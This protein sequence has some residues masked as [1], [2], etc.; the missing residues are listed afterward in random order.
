MTPKLILLALLIFHGEAFAASEQVSFPGARGEGYP[1]TE[2]VTGTLLI[3][4]N[5]KSP[6]P[7]IVLLHGSGGIDGRGAFHAQALNKAGIATLE[8]FMFAGGNRFKAG[9]TATLSH[10]YGALKFLTERPN[11]DSKKI[12]VMGFSWGGN[13]SLRTASK[14]VHRKFFPDGSPM[15][16][17]HA[18]YYAVW[19]VHT[20]LLKNSS[21]NGYG[22]YAEMT[23]A[24][25]LLFAGGMD[26]YGVPDAAQQFL[27]ALPEQAKKFVNLQYYPDATH[28]WDSPA[29]R[30]RT[31]FDPVAQ[32]G[33]GGQV[34]FFPDRTV[35]EDSKNKTVDFFLKSFEIAPR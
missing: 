4:D 27:D 3:P 5:A 23:G 18:P 10:A 29:D 6:M 11:I 35:A 14:A 9:H 7:A 2:Q 33:K 25:V 15:F 21:V 32:E 24:P 22:D 12:G 16:A 8:V 1:Y 30:K 34:R 28:G 17:A 26:D 31:I 20:Q 13:L 19:W